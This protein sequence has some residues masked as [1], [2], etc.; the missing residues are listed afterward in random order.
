MCEIEACRI[1]LRSGIKLYRMEVFNLSEYYEELIGHLIGV[2]DDLP[3][4]FCYECSAMLHKFHKFKE[5]CNYTYKTLRTLLRKGKLTYK[6]INNVINKNDYILKY[7]NLEILTLSK[8]IKTYTTEHATIDVD[9]KENNISADKFETLDCYNDYQS[10]YEESCKDPTIDPVSEELEIKDDT[11][12]KIEIVNTFKIDESVFVDSSKEE[13]KPKP[14]HTLKRNLRLKKGNV[15]TDD[16]KEYRQHKSKR[17]SKVVP[18]ETK[19]YK[20]KSKNGNL[21]ALAFLNSGFWKKTNLSE[22]EALKDFKDRSQDRKYLKAAYKCEDCYRGFSQ[23]S[24][25]DRHIPLRHGEAAGSLS[26]RFC[27]MR[28][29]AAHYLNKHMRQHFTKYECLRCNLVCNLENSALFHEEYHNG[30]IR[31]CTHCD[32]EFRHLSTFYTHLRTHRS[33]HMCSL[34]GESFVSQLGLRLHKKVKHAVETENQESPIKES[35]NC[36]ICQIKFDTAEAYDKHLLHSAMHTDENKLIDENVAK[37]FLDDVDEKEE[38]DQKS[39]PLIKRKSRVEKTLSAVRKYLPRKTTA[40]KPTTCHQCGKHFETQSACM[41]HHLAEHP[42]TSFFSAKERIICEVCGASLAPGS[43]AAHLNQHTRRKMYTCDTC[44]RSFT[45]S[46]MLRNHMVTHTGEKRYGC[47]LCDKRFTQNGSLSLHYR[48]FHLKQPYPKRNRR[49]N[50]DKPEGGTFIR[51]EDQQ[52][53]F[54]QY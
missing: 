36:D 37:D 49:K 35:T 40:K 26:C 3:C 12:S 46:T 38:Y 21:K 8:R 31:K 22:E 42:R 2:N 10:D 13:I 19:K 24:M 51:K 27:K 45:T 47:S 43:V 44:G 48:T 17:K 25:L 9:V 54:I 5:K 15:F 50:S 53:E 52:G 28:F 11:F 23:K 30:V 29:K 16:E 39:E 4:C 33:K 41:K 14:R 34:C 7:G 1:C 18:S 6:S 20:F 32:K